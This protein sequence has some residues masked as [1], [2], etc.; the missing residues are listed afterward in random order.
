M[1]IGAPGGPRIITAV[2]QVVLRVVHLGQG[3][4][5][6]V[7]APL[8]E[9]AAAPA[10]EALLRANRRRAAAGGGTAAPLTL[11]SVQLVGGGSRVPVRAP[12]TP[13]LNC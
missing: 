8:L 7:A 3:L 4:V 2:T 5:E 10:A 13:G 9:R 6:A 12:A 1:V 11:G